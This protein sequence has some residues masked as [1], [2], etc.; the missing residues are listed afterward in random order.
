MGCRVRSQFGVISCVLG[1]G[2]RLWGEIQCGLVFWVASAIRLRTRW[3]CLWSWA[4][5]KTTTACLKVCWL[6]LH[7]QISR[8]AECASCPGVRLSG[9]PGRH[10]T[11]APNTDTDTKIDAGTSTTQTH[12]EGMTLNQTGKMQYTRYTEG[13]GEVKW[14]LTNATATLWDMLSPSPRRRPMW[15]CMSTVMRLHCYRLSSLE[16]SPDRSTV[17]QD[18]QMQSELKVVV[19]AASDKCRR[20]WSGKRVDRVVVL[21]DWRSLDVKFTG[22]LPLLSHLASAPHL[23]LGGLLQGLP[24]EY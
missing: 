1:D 4:L 7:T 9:T 10:K 18:N 5:R 24:T 23:S 2:N 6:L 22:P 3:A 14:R 12:T 19:W 8:K 15:W 17:L 20:L 13:R 11:I 16:A 21:W